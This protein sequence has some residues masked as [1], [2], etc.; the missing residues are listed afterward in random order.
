MRLS[1]LT[2]LLPI[3]A[4]LTMPVDTRFP[5][6]VA[7]PLPQLSDT[8]M[9]VLH[10]CVRASFRFH[11]QIMVTSRHSALRS[12]NQHGSRIYF[13]LCTEIVPTRLKRS[14]P[15]TGC[16]KMPSPL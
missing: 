15:A 16:S 1:V 3:A 4:A 11:A 6:G 5:A 7:E 12:L 9:T 13:R 14:A 8:T 2:S 10:Q